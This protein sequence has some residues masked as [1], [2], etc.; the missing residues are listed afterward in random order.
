MNTF[1]RSTGAQHAL[2]R[3]TGALLAVFAVASLSAC[4]SNEARSLL[5]SIESGQV[6]LGTKFDQ[7]GLGVR[8]PE[9][10][11]QG[12]DTDVARYVVNYIADKK[13][14]EEPALTWRETPSAQ[15]ETLINNGE[16]DM[17]AATYSIS[18]SR[19]RSVDFAGPYLV[20]HQALLV[21]EDSKI[22]GLQD[23]GADTKL[24]SVTGSTPA[25]KIKDAL[26]EVQLQEFD[27]YSA[28]VEALSR[29]KVDAMT[30]DATILAGFAEQYE[31]QMR[32]VEMKQED[33]SYWTNENYGIGMAKGQEEAVELVNE[34]LNEMHDSGEY[35][36]IME[37][38]LGNAIAPGDKPAIGDLSFTQES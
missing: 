12:V 24:C 19:L 4:G 32:V 15:R 16:V 1:R 14:W 33:G 13:G 29:G 10:D 26:P 37:A 11:F 7:P 35:A 6:I 3:L 23:M 36:R 30:T 25:Q 9:K 28:C 27:T 17:I 5:G 8:T 20:T 31:G 34:A 21:R 38:N 22:Q 2:R 18:A